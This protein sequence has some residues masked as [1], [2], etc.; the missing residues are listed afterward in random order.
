M[1]QLTDNSEEIMVHG[2]AVAV[3]V[4]P[5]GPLAG[6]LL[7]GASGKGKSQTALS[8][9]NECRWQRTRLVAD[10]CVILRSDGESLLA[11]PPEALTGKVEL[12]GFGPIEIPVQKNIVVKLVLDLDKSLARIPA[13]SSYEPTDDGPWAPLLPFSSMNSGST[14]ARVVLMLRSFL[15]GQ[16]P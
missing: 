4:D 14:S 12:R 9:I 5:D 2:V 1:N 8:L 11:S 10:D 13:I 7:I 15:A 16:I 6:V 3:A